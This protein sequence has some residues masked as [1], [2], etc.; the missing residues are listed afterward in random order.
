MEVGDLLEKHLFH[1]EQGVEEVLQFASDFEPKKRA[2]KV[3]CVVAVVAGERGRTV[4]LKNEILGRE[5]HL[6]M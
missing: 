3:D 1:G 5:C 6:S 2:K 4:G